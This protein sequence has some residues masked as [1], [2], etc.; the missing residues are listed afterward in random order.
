MSELKREIP[1]KTIHFAGLGYIPAYLYFGREFVL[2]AVI[3][4]L[5]TSL[6]LEIFRLRYG[7]AQWMA[8]D[9]EKDRVGAHV[10]FGITILMITA[11]FQADSCFV[12]VATSIL[13]DG[14]AG[15]LKRAGLSKNVCS[16]A[17]FA[18]SISLVYFFSLAEFSAAAV[19]CAAA[20]LVERIDRV[21]RYYLEDN[22]SVPLTAAVVYSSVKYIWT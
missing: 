2:L 20:T 19:A 17:M 18:A 22:V 15:L 16:A 5:L 3:V 4:A 6:I 1:R 21:G 11:L 14:V 10:Y 7:F 9:H 12:A 8:R 13:G